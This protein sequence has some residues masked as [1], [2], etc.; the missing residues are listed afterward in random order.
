VRRTVCTSILLCVG[1]AACGKSGHHRATTVAKA[2]SVVHPVVHRAPPPKPPTP[3]QLVR[4]AVLR[5]GQ[6][7]AAR[8]YNAICGLLAAGLLTHLHEAGIPCTIA[9]SRGLTNVVNPQLTVER[10]TVRG[11]RAS[12]LVHTSAFSQA[13]AASVLQLVREAGG[14]KIASL[15]S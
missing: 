12:V 13:S 8:D 5:Y 1:L 15:A 4:A 6:A 14:W 3:G 10:V 9:V 2:T 7:V 11:A